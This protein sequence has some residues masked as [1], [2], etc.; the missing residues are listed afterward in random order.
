MFIWYHVGM[1][2]AVH[3]PVLVPKLQGCSVLQSVSSH[4]VLSLHCFRGQLLLRTVHP[5]L[6]TGHQAIADQGGQEELL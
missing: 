1:L 4:D 2:D 6:A 5:T 3:E